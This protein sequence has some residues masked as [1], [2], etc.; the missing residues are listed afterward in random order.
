MVYIII[1]TSIKIKIIISKKNFIYYLL[2]LFKTIK[3]K[4]LKQI[5]YN[6]LYIKFTY[7]FKFINFN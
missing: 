1:Y 2:L 5:N 6:F 3:A 7:L 4:I